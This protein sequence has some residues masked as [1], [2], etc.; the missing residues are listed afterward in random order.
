M[1]RILATIGCAGLGFW[2]GA[3]HLVP[4]WAIVALAVL[5]AGLWVLAEWL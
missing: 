4:L 3:N 1:G 2:L 5:G